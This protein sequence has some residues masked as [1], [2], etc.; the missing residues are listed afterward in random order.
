MKPSIKIFILAASILLAWQGQAQQPFK[1][2]S[3]LQVINENNPMLKDY[4]FRAEAMTNFAAGA[5]SLMA[6]E[7]GGGPWMFPYPGAKIG[8]ER[9]KGQ[10]MLSVQQ[11]FTSPAKLR[12]NQSYLNSKAGIEKA[13]ETFT[14]N[15]LRALAKTAFYQWLVLEKKKKVLQE[16]EEIIRLVLKISRVRYPYNQSKL[17]T[18]YK[19][20]GRLLEVQ[21]MILMNDNE[22]IQKNILLNQLMN[23][24][25]DLRFSID[26]TI[27]YQQFVPELVDTAI[28]AQSRSDVRRI[29]KSI[30]SMRLNQALEKYQARPDF[31]INYNHMIPRGSGMP[32]QYMLLG[33]I[34]IPIAPWSS[35]MYKSNI[36]GM[37]SQIESMKR[38]RESI[39]NEL[40]G[41]TSGMVNEINTL[42]QQVNNYEKKIIP[43]LRKNYETL[44]LAYEE[45]KEELY[46]VIDAY[47]TLIMSQSQYLDTLKRYYETVVYYEKLLEK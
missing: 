18:I 35:K 26:T 20:E 3:I 39:L 37:G 10:I 4:R 32:S 34:S 7:V 12:A 2:D 36:K 21:N 47:E 16:N 17:G 42:N 33:M 28:L 1:L 8:D 14:Y 44:M 15:E 38:E 24:P 27:Q 5:K 25:K 30:Q 45:N 41:M 11:K 13:S 19:A 23:R 43:V 40:Q 31:T 22:I 46:I 29:D 6:P 9:D